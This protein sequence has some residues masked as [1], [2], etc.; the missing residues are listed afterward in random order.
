MAT[1]ILAKK[2]GMKVLATTRQATKSAALER[3]GVDQILIDD[4]SICDE[5]KRA[6]AGGVDRALELVG[7]P[8]L[9]DTLAATRVH[10]VVC[11]TGMLSG[12]WIVE[13]FYPIDYIPAGVRL[14][15]YSGEA[16]DLL[17]DVLQDFIDDVAD[18]KVTVP[19]DSVF[20]LEQI[21]QAHSLMESGTAAGKIVV[22]P[23]VATP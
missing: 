19:I 18:G 22:L 9:R 1:A 21:R 4:G 7:A 14:T 5:V 16:S 13:D 20:S 11:F 12:H 23:E 8:T 15:A 10:G 6:V 2:M 3:I 17:T